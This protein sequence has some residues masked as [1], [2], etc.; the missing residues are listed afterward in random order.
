LEGS[1]IGVPAVFFDLAALRDVAAREVLR[2]L[3]SA[4]FLGR[5]AGSFTYSV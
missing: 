2:G 5:F 1:L 3:F 4:Q